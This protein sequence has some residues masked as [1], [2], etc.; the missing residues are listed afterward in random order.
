M[1]LIKS[2]FKLKNSASLNRSSFTGNTTSALFEIYQEEV[3]IAIWQRK[4][5]SKIMLASNNIL[6]TYPFLEISEVI[7]PKDVIEMLDSK[8]G[9]SKDNIYLSSDIS[10]LVNIFCDLFKLDRVGFRLKILDHAMCPRFH[11]DRVPCRLITTY[12]GIATEWL[13]H[14]KVDRSKLGVA[15]HGKIDEETGIFKTHKDIE[16]LDVGHVGLLKGESWEKNEGAGL[17]HRSPKVEDNDQRRLM[18]TLDFIDDAQ[19]NF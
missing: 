9:T 10:D 14:C 5:S 12:H 7:N 1:N 17:V 11:V 2:C 3:N 19:L 8:I 4:L 15:S 13:P 6:Q 16:Q 18:L